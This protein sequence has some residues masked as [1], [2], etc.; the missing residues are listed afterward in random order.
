MYDDEAAS[1]ELADDFD[2]RMLQL[3]ALIGDVRDEFARDPDIWFG[4]FDVSN[5]SIGAMCVAR[6]GQKEQNGIIEVFLCNDEKRSMMPGHSRI[7]STESR[8]PIEISRS[9]AL[10]KSYHWLPEFTGFSVRVWLRGHKM[11]TVFRVNGRFIDRKDN[12]V[13]AADVFSHVVRELADLSR[14]HRL[15]TA[16]PPEYVGQGSIK[17]LLDDIIRSY[18]LAILTTLGILSFLPFFICVASVIAAEFLSTDTIF[19]IVVSTL[20]LPGLVAGLLPGLEERTIRCW[21]RI[22]AAAS[23]LTIIAFGFFGLPG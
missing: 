10:N 4:R 23:G 14:R 22:L 6:I 12:A 3:W 5:T 15:E 7:P 21:H 2:A 17:L 1:W 11:K 18:R 20:G 8:K 16:I 19:T 13:A 9:E